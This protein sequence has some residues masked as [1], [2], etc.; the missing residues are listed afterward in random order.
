MAEML[1]IRHAQASFGARDYDRLSDL[2]HRQ[3]AMVGE[4]LRAA[5]WVPERIVTG[6]LRRQRETLISLGYTRPPEIHAGF[7]E[8]DF[9]NL[10]AARFDGKVPDQVRHDRK[11]HFDTLRE[12]ILD[13]QE[14]GLSQAGESW[15]DFA[16]RVEAARRF[17]TDT[18]AKRV[19]VISS[20]GVIGQLVARALKA[21][22]QSMVAL[23]LQ[24][25]NTALTRFFFS[26]RSFLLHEF[27]ATPH[28]GDQ[29]S[30]TFMT[31]S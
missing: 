31:Y 25:K 19:L 15:K 2:G 21:P 12:V 11:T 6:T 1:V 10:L 9:H 7:D 29:A 30:A 13:W 18:G 5:A 14:G 3:S 23:N 20:G 16:Q 26:E 28:F 4:A 17:A 8:Y 27:N 22:A 24:V